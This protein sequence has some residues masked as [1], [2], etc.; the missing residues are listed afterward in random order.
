MAF[1]WS[2]RLTLWF[3]GWSTSSAA[4][5]LASLFLLAMLSA[6]N[7]WLVFAGRGRGEQA[8]DFAWDAS[9][10]LCGYL[11]MLAVMTYNVGVLLTVVT[12]TALVR[13]RL[14]VAGP[15]AIPVSQPERADVT[16]RTCE[17]V[18]AHP[19]LDDEAPLLST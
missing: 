9:T 16:P 15:V 7:E 14:R 3:D 8:R 18:A 10:L 12:A 2:A 11:L 5:Y 6:L 19:A 1:S 13:G 17:L 4:G